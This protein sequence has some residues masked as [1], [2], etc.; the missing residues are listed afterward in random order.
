M[1]IF[2]PRSLLLRQ[3]ARA[4]KRDDCLLSGKSVDRRFHS[5][6][7]FVPHKSASQDQ[8]SKKTFLALLANAAGHGHGTGKAQAVWDLTV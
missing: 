4:R 6:V 2:K 7:G 5:D 3:C 1:G 8:W